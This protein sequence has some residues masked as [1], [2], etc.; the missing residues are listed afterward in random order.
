MRLHKAV[1]LK[2]NFLQTETGSA[3]TW[4]PRRL[5][6]TQEYSSANFIS[7]GFQA[8][9]KKFGALFWNVE[10]NFVSKLRKYEIALVG[11]FLCKMLVRQLY[12]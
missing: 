1:Q 10:I 5:C 6:I 4:P 8:R 3:A 9:S 2:S 12:L 7:L 11:D